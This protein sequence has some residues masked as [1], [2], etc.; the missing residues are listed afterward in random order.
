M[1]IANRINSLD[2]MSDEYKKTGKK[3]YEIFDNL[4]L[5]L[6]DKD[7]AGVIADEFRDPKK[8]IATLLLVHDILTLKGIGDMGCGQVSTAYVE[9]LIGAILEERENED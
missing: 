4:E 3:Y 9:D 2:N 7:L 6:H 1:K 5:V 8:R